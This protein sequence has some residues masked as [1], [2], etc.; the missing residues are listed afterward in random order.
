MRQVE[1]RGQRANN[2]EWVYGYY[3]TYNFNGEILHVIIDDRCAKY[4][5]LLIR[6]IPVVPETVGMYT[7]L[8]DCKRT[9]EYP[10]GQKIWEGD[11]F[12]EDGGKIM[13]I[14]Y[15][16]G[17]FWGKW[18]KHREHRTA[19]FVLQ[20]WWEHVKVI[21]NKWQNPELLKVKE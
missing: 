20:G 2:G 9:E 1:F 18:I 10:E 12:Y 6:F 19:L 21:G 14:V 13:E 4:V 5:P 11:L 8:R 16:D 17:C 3:V 15:E 7:G